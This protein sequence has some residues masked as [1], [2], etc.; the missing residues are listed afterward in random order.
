MDI[1]KSEE[2][3][4]KKKKKPVGGAGISLKEHLCTRTRLPLWVTGVLVEEM[5]IQVGEEWVLRE[6]EAVV[7]AEVYSK[8]GAFS[9]RK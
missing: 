5:K 6:W 1:L 8:W 9:W 7:A 3:K 2:K 4:K